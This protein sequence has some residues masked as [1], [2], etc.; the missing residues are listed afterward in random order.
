MTSRTRSPDTA[1]PGHPAVSGSVRWPRPARRRRPGPGGSTWRVPA[2]LV[3]L[4]AVP[5]VAGSLRLLEVAGGPLL[6]PT[7]P[8]IDTSPAPAVLHV[9]A[10]TLYLL[11]GAFQL[12]PGCVGARQAGTGAPGASWSGP[13]W[14]SRSPH[15][16]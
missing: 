4:S 16:G 10:A 2:A 3:V 9:V 15:S 8:R 1:R 12:S 14:S 13:G 5:V 11:L 6:L 7:N